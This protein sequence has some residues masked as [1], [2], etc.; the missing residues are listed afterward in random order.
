MGPF[1]SS[2]ADL[3]RVRQLSCPDSSE[4]SGR[5]V[6]IEARTVRTWANRVAWWGPR[7]RRRR[8][9]RCATIR[10]SRPDPPARP[11]G[12]SQV[13][14]GA[15]VGD[16]ASTALGARPRSNGP[17]CPAD[18]PPQPRLLWS[19]TSG[20][21]PTVGGVGYPRSGS[22][23]VTAAG[24]RVQ[25][26]PA[27]WGQERGFGRVPTSCAP[28]SRRFRGVEAGFHTESERGASPEKRA[29]TP[30]RAATAGDAG[31]G[32]QDERDDDP[33][34][35]GQKG[36]E[37]EPLGS[38]QTAMFRHRSRRPRTPKVGASPPHT[39]AKLNA[40]GGRFTS[41]DVTEA[42]RVVDHH[43]MR[44]ASI[45]GPAYRARAST[46]RP[47]ACV[48]PLNG[49]PLKAA[50]AEP[51][52]SRGVPATD[53]PGQHARAEKA[54]RARRPPRSGLVRGRDDQQDARTQQ[55][56]ASLGGQGAHGPGAT[57]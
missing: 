23:L 53:D 29:A 31:G 39:A 4:P 34:H 18:P 40:V 26:H 35:G 2:R 12:P 50:G 11:A 55:R 41:A 51:P 37:H 36:Q 3:A 10:C 22:E 38:G 48:N 43:A 56:A 15:A 27:L 25:A 45:R 8:G 1:G 49:A 17:S 46:R 42:V 13:R 19:G 57:T 44:G 28:A 24:A 14:T 52:A 33:R 54:P 21:A 20:Q 30:A 16:L 6:P 7:A 9:S 5:G 47:L 32:L